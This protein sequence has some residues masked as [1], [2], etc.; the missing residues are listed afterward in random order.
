[1]RERA[2]GPARSGSDLEVLG[3]AVVAPRAMR[4]RPGRRPIN[5]PV[6]GA[7]PGSHGQRELGEAGAAATL[8]GGGT[9]GA[10]VARWH[11]FPAHVGMCPGRQSVDVQ[12]SADGADR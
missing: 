10:M 11:G 5:C 7:V 3:D 1:M 8:R 4:E 2:A 6:L 9:A 12:R